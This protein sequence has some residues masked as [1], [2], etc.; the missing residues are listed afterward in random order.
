MLQLGLGLLH[1]G[2]HP[3]LLSVCEFIYIY[4]GGLLDTWFRR[5]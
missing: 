2:T 5:V 4:V 1:V 3:D